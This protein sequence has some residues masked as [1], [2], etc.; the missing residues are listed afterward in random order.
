M[1]SILTTLGI[2][3][4][5][6]FVL[7]AG[8]AA[9]YY[10]KRDTFKPIIKREIRS[11]LGITESLELVNEQIEWLSD[12]VEKKADAPEIEED[13][14]GECVETCDGCCEECTCAE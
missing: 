2:V 1:E 7:L 10:V 3:C 6:E 11:W 8:V 12:E 5:G 9:V 4:V 14:D 13:E